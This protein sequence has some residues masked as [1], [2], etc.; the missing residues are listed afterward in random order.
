M[1]LGST[2]TWSDS[3][4]VGG[5]EV[6][7]WTHSCKRALREWAD[8]VGVFIPLEDHYGSVSF[9]EGGLRFAQPVDLI[10]RI[11]ALPTGG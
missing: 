4:S 6:L 10:K 2:P 8:Y 3:K 1:A 7:S 11:K 9:L 5:I